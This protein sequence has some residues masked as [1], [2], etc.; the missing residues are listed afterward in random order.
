MKLLFIIF[1]LF[2]STYTLH[3]QTYQVSG[4]VQG[5]DKTPLEGCSVWFLQ[6]DTLAG[7]CVT[8]RKAVSS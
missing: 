8:T 1:S 2:I 3:A 6:A 7:G 4:S 5:A